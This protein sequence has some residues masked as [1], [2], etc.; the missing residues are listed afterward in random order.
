MA[1]TDQDT[2]AKAQKQMNQTALEIVKMSPD[3]ADA[4]TIKEF[5]GD[6]LKRALSVAVE[7]HI[8]K[9]GSVS[10]AE[11]LAR[12]GNLYGTS[13]NDLSEQYKAALR[14]IEQHEALKIKFESA[15]S[16]LAVERQKLNL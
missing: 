1:L 6:R 4:K 9:A 15:R 13:L 5:N 14:V 8:F 16:I 7:E 12:A 3:V 2:I 11:H 10:G